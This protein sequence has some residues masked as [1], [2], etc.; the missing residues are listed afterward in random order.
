[1]AGIYIH[2]P[3]CAQKCSY[4]DFHFSTTFSSYRSELIHALVNELLLRKNNDLV[5]TIYFGG[6]TPSLLT[7]EELKILIE[8]IKLNFNCATEIELTLECNPD[9]CSLTNLSN[10]KELGINRLSIGIQSF[11]DEQLKWMNRKHTSSQAKEALDIAQKVGF[12]NITVDLIYGLPNLT[13]KEWERQLMEIIRLPI[14]HISAYCLTVEE[15]TVLAKWVKEKKIVPS[16]NDEQSDQFELLVA[17][18]S[19]NGF[20]QY[21]ISNFCREENYSKHNSSYWLGKK[22]LGIGPSAHG[23]DGESRY[24][25]IASNQ[26]YIRSIKEGVLPET[27]EKLGINEQFNELILLGLRTKWGVNKSQLFDLIQP[28][29]D[30]V[31]QKNSFIEMGELI[32]TENF[33][34]LTE[35]GKLRADLIASELFIV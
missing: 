19:K 14:Q 28:T 4:C 34:H 30:W 17:T 9:D 21:E 15:K 27:K 26:Q 10:W 22:F 32:E 20:E 2:I 35:T 3:F 29:L 11:D 5:E 12:T 18:L 7:K 16:D 8:T 31:S 33:L 25:N 6:G 24:W 23:Y 13:L 1:M